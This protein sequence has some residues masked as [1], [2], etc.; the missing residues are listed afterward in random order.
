MAKVN[1][2]FETG[3][4][5]V[6]DDEFVYDRM[7]VALDE[8]LENMALVSKTDAIVINGKVTYKHIDSTKIVASDIK[9]AD[10]LKLISSSNMKIGVYD[11]DDHV[12]VS[13]TDHDYS[14]TWVIKP[15]ANPKH[16]E[17]VVISTYDF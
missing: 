9:A 14:T 6:F 13:T 5:P 17:V 8:L 1:H 12:R 10:L 11:C 7:A 4:N 15:F 16:G 3:Y 2:V